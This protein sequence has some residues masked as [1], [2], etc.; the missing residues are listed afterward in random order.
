M[1]A[2]QEE[3]DASG[4][5]GVL[6]LLQKI[7]VLS[8]GEKCA[9]LGAWAAMDPDV[10]SAHAVHIPIQETVHAEEI[11]EVEMTVDEWIESLSELPLR[12]Q[13][14]TLAAELKKVEDESDRAA[15]VRAMKGIC[16]KDKVLAIEVAVTKLA[17]EQPLWIVAGICGLIFVGIAI[18][19]FGFRLMF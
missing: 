8:P 4:N 3:P 10:H 11:Q 18:S 5:A 7:M 19:K 9:L 14:V 1:R 12:E 13:Y 2:T 6:E 16:N 15:I 17:Y